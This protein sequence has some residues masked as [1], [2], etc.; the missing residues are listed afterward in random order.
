I[1]KEPLLGADYQIG[2]AYLMNLKY[3][4]SLTVTE[5]RSRI[6]D[7][8]IR[9]LLQEYLRGSNES[10]LIDSFAKAFGI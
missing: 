7:D 1:T 8:C 3:A 5:V 10:E 9:P 4:R 6:W 2:H